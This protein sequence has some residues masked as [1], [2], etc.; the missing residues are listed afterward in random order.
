EV[1]PFGEETEDLARFAL[2]YEMTCSGFPVTVI[3][4]S[5][6]EYNICVM[7]FLRTGDIRPFYKAM[8]RAVYNKLEV[9]LQV[10]AEEEL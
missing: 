4:M 9:I 10:T 3:S 8:E 7:D 1:Y 2:L 5:E 6:Q